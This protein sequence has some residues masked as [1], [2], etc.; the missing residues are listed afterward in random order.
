MPELRPRL[1]LGA[2]PRRRRPA[3]DGRARHRHGRRHRRARG[4]RRAGI[5]RRPLPALLG[6][7]ADRRPRGAAPRRARAGSRPTRRSPPR[8]PEFGAGRDDVVRLR[9]LVSH[10]LG[11]RRAADGRPAG[12]RRVAARTRPRLRRGHRVAV[13]D[14]RVRGRR[15]AHRARR[16]RPVG[17][18][19]SPPSA[20]AGRRRPGSRST[21][22]RA[23]TRSVDAAAQGLDYARFA[24]LRHP[25]AGLLG[26]AED[27]LARR[28]RAAAQRRIARLARDR[29]RRCC[30]RSP[31]GCRSSSRTPR[32]AA[33]TGASRGTC[34]TRRPACSRATRY[35]H[36]GWARHRVLDHAVARRVLRAA[37]ERRRRHRPVRR[38]RRRA[39]QRGRGRRRLTAPRRSGR[40]ARE[41]PVN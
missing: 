36:G 9:H 39:A 28:Q 17:A 11:H 41:Y 20:S 25:G 18:R 19:P 5:R 6:D 24:A 37:H 23:R 2:P 22:T 21:P 3:A 8:V 26:R 31:S 12:L 16:R 13:L 10:T 15:R 38:R 29:R 14:A 35:G 4:V 30:A 40:R 7:E 34:G 27:L 1:R 32:R 33:R